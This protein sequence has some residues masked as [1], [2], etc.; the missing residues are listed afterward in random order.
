MF[1]I[2]KNKIFCIGYNKTGT[3]SLEKVLMDFDF[4]MGKQEEAEL[5]IKNY[6]EKD[7]KPIVKY[8]KK[9]EAFQDVPFSLPYLWIILKEH[10]PN[11]KFILTIRD[12]NKWYNSITKFHSNK[13]ADGARVPEKN[14]LINATY[15]YKGFLWDYNRAV[16][17]TPEDDIYNKELL[18]ESYNKH[19]KEVMLYFKNDPNFICIDVSKNSDYKQL[20][21][22]LKKESNNECFPHLNITDL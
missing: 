1:T 4:K 10:Y 12:P 2:N 6:L 17:N 9:A 3:T 15:R 11:A 22:F 7:Y 16:F 18:L 13:F 5:L 19:N 8:C 20:C 21:K 14:D